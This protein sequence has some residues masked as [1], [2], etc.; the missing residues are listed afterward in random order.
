VSDFDLNEPPPGTFGSPE[1]TCSETC[2]RDGNCKAWTFVKAGF[3]GPKP[4]CYLKNVIPRAFTNNCCVSGVP[5]RAFEPD[6]DR[7][8]GDYNN[9]DL[10]ADNPNLC[11]EA[12]QND[13]SQCKA[14]TFVKAGFQGPKPRCW[15][16]NTIP[17][18]FINN[19]C[20]S[21]APQEPILR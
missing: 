21:G 9:F 12:C 7:P 3:Q 1:Y 19:C 4:R 17:P 11:K 13:R 8:G 6:I 18:A 2:Q 20:T 5:V 16:K 15:L 10:A 14:W